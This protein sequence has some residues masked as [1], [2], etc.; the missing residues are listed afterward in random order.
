LTSAV[1]RVHAWLSRSHSPYSERDEMS[2]PEGFSLAEK[3]D[4][5]NFMTRKGRTH[6][7]LGAKPTSLTTLLKHISSIMREEAALV[8]NHH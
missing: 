7:S 2:P 3:A 1:G 4:V 5:I 6:V 8:K